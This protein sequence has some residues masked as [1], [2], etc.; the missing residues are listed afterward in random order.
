VRQVPPGRVTTYGAVA[1]FA[2]Q[3]RA[4]RQVGYAMAALKETGPNGDVPWQRVLGAASRERARVSIRDPDGGEVQRAM[5]EA[6]GVV[7]DALGRVELARFGWAGPT[8]R[9]A[10][11]GRTVSRS[12]RA[13]SRSTG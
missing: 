11:R 9:R 7:F 12:R 3:P 4:A 13:A 6:E 1:A 5:L 2:G 10:R 8:P